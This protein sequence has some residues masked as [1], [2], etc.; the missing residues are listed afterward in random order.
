M[1]LGDEGQHATLTSDVQAIRIRNDLNRV[2]GPASKAI[3]RIEHLE[4]P[5]Q[6]EFIDWRHDDDDDPA[7]RGM[8]TQAMFLECGGHLLSTMPP[9]RRVRKWNAPRWRISA[10]LCRKSA[11][12]P[13]IACLS[14]SRQ[15]DRGCRDTR[16]S[17]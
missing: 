10:Y 6:I 9:G 4:R 13:S 11:H 15:A 17:V 3:D 5:D 14:V 12:R 8:A 16:R 1:L 7:A 2:D